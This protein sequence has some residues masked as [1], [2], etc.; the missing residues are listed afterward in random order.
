MK[1]YTIKDEE[2]KLYPKAFLSIPTI[3]KTVIDG[4]VVEVDYGLEDVTAYIEKSKGQFTLA[5]CEVLE[6][7]K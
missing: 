1:V 3:S 4:Q 6:I 2:G 7:S 5:V